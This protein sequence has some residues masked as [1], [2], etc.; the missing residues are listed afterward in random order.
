MFCAA[1][2]FMMRPGAFLYDGQGYSLNHSGQELQVNAVI[3]YNRLFSREKHHLELSG[4]LFFGEEIDGKADDFPDLPALTGTFGYRFMPQEFGKFM[5]KAA[6]TP[7]FAQNKIYP[8]VGF[9]IGY[10]F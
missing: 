2:C 6:F 9:S 7:I 10:T 1:A 5:L 3:M 4:G 8:R